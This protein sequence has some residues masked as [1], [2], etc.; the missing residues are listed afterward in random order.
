MVFLFATNPT[1]TDFREF[2]P[3]HARVSSK[4]YKYPKVNV[5]K[6]ANYFFYSVYEYEIIEDTKHGDHHPKEAGEFIGFI[7]NFYNNTP[8]PPVIAVCTGVF[9]DSLAMVAEQEILQQE[10]KDQLPIPPLKRTED[11]LPILN[12]H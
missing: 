7:N 11:G 3:T 10:Q 2:I 5:A 4:G 1:I 9:K 6:K 8:S 12:K